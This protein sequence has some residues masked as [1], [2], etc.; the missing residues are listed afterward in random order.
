MCDHQDGHFGP[1]P[2]VEVNSTAT[3]ATP[4]TLQEQPP[5]AFPL[6]LVLTPVARSP[7]RLPDETIRTVLDRP[8]PPPR[9]S[10][11]THASRSAE[12]GSAEWERSPDSV[13][14]NAGELSRPINSFPGPAPTASI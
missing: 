1:V 12:S 3:V 4:E 5:A 8:L 10:D 6:S 13:A 14:S 7:L 11:G 9:T 2:N